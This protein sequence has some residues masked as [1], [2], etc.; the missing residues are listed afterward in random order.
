M[1]VIAGHSDKGRLVKLANG[2]DSAV[3][4]LAQ[5]PSLSWH[6]R[7]LEECAGSEVEGEGCHCR[8]GDDS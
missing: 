3:L 8:Y 5:G 2:V 6:R 7:I 1:V 4:L